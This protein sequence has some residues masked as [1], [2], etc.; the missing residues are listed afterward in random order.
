MFRKRLATA[1]IALPLISMLLFSY[2][3][4]AEIVTIDPDNYPLGTNLTHAVPGV[5]LNEF[6][7]VPGW[8]APV[9]NDV[10]AVTGIPCRIY[11][12]APSDVRVSEGVAVF[13][14]GTG[15]TQWFDVGQISGGW[16]FPD[17]QPVPIQERSPRSYTDTLLITFDKPTNYV[18]FKGI[19]TMDGLVGVG[20]GEDGYAITGWYGDTD[21]TVSSRETEGFYDDPSHGVYLSLTTI[22]MRS[23]K[24]NIAAVYMGGYLGGAGV[25]SISFSTVPIPASAWLFGAGLLGLVGVKCKNGRRVEG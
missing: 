16:F 17:P 19:W 4:L 13:G 12:S 22:T 1:S 14:N 21:G 25:E 24:N 23:T 8:D 15:G 20:V 9:Y 5:T 18:S 3:A 10:Y 6:K 11:C 2:K 7:Y